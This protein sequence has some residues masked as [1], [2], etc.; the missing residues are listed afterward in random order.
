[1]QSQ[2]QLKTWAAI[3]FLLLLLQN[4][5]FLDGQTAPEKPEIIKCRSPEKETFSCWWKPGYDG[6][7]PTNYTLLYTKENH[8]EV[9]E[10]PDYK[11][12]GPYSC[13]FD[14]KHTSLWTIYIIVVN[15]TNEKGSNA[16]EPFFVD[17][18]YIIEPYPPTNVSLTVEKKHL[19]V[20]WFP[21]LLVDVKYGWLTLVYELRLKS[22]KAQ[23][24]EIH[25]T[26][27]QTHFKVFSLHP[28]ENH[29]VQVRCKPDH[30]F[31]SEWSPE[32]YVQIPKI[33]QEKDMTV[34]ISV[35]L[36]AFIIGLIVIWTMVLKG[37]KNMTCI[38]P[39]VPGPKIIGF[40]T[41]LLKTGKSEELLSALGSQGF[42]PTS[43][44]EEL[45]VDYV[46]VDDSRDQ[47]I[48]NEDKSHPDPNVK[49]PHFETDNDS[50]RGSCD[51][52]S[53]F[54]ERC[55]GTR[56][57]PSTFESVGVDGRLKNT[58]G[59]SSNDWA[60]QCIDPE[61][62]SYAWPEEMMPNNHT[63][64]SSYH[65]IT[66]V[67]K[68]VNKEDYQPKYFKTIK[69]VTE[70][71]RSQ[72]KELKEIQSK[73]GDHDTVW[74]LPQEKA[75]FLSANTMDYVEVH[76]ISQNNALALV[77]KH[78]ETGDRSK[79]GSVSGP[80]KEYTKV[81]RVDDN[82]VLVLVQDAGMQNLPVFLDSHK[83]YCQI[84]PQQQGENHMGN[85]PAV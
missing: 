65:N 19:L 5:K 30:G 69:S 32:S 37:Y 77:P 31:W 55:R 35:A 82:N 75:P 13:Y 27:K 29:V 78:K 7:L 42:P 11:T 34:W 83:E 26:G 3:T 4:T 10:C 73:P 36:L 70:E 44:Y 6:G 18:T 50:G 57:I 39:Q 22:E 85:C 9:I 23:E 48:S 68:L 21:P 84:F 64:K 59:H 16:S 14:K 41:Q 25:F 2:L 80:N 79:R 76:K 56:V 1:M 28:G 8:P 52:P 24:W 67:C 20:K 63:P 12:S 40:D 45:L 61:E 81:A 43:D 60:T 38:F 66:E 53:A 46:E 58:A 33:F 72:Q 71:D 15:A 51:S 47:L 17:V 62:K 74:L 54:S 49:S